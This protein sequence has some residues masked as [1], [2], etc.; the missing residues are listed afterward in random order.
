VVWVRAGSIPHWG[1]ELAQPIL[2]AYFM[3]CIDGLLTFGFDICV[4]QI[5][6][7]KR[8]FILFI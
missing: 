3:Y 1:D 8:E 2:A 6:E 7:I 4:C 5:F